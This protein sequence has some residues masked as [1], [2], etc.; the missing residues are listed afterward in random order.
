MLYLFAILFGLAYGEILCMMSL[1]PADLF[2]LKSQGTI[3]GIVVFAS[4]LGGGMGPIAAGA[5]FDLTGSY[6]TVF[7]ACI[8][9]AIIGLVMAICI[10]P[11]RVGNPAVPESN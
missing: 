6:Q 11:V 4:T 8:A 3:L 10:R 1:L 2:G 9:A 5:I 7:M